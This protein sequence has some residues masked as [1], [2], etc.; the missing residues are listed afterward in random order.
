MSPKRNISNLV[1]SVFTNDPVAEAAPIPSNEDKQAKVTAAPDSGTTVV[2]EL[3]VQERPRRAPKWTTLARKDARIR[4]D[5]DEALHSLARR[6]SRLRGK[7]DE[8]ITDNTLI[9]VAIDLL[10][11]NQDALAGTTEE[12]LRA[13]VLPNFRTSSQ[14]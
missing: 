5:Q 14:Q 11:A 13:S 9:R 4:Y 3:P 12:E 7:S 8:R 10:L 1:N 6:L 2:G